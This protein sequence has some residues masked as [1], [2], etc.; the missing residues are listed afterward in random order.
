MSDIQRAPEVGGLSH[1]RYLAVVKALARKLIAE[2]EESCLLFLG[3]GAGFD[4]RR[5]HLP[6]AAEL[7]QELAKECKLE[8]HE[9]VPLSTVAFY[10]EFFYGREELNRF[11]KDR[12][13]DPGLQPS[14][15][16]ERL[17]E[18][19]AILEKLKRVVL[20]VTTNYDQHFERAYEAAFGKKPNVIVYNGGM[21]A[22]DPTA[23]LHSG[24]AKNLRTWQ[25]NRGTFLY[26]MH[27]C[28]TQATGR[29]LVVTEEDYV[30]FLSN[31]LSDFPTKRLPTYL[32]GRIEES[33]ILFVGYSLSDWNFRVI[34]KATAERASPNGVPTKESFA[35]QYIDMTEA[36]PIDQLRWASPVEFWGKKNVKIINADAALFV[37]DLVTALRELVP[38]GAL[39]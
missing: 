23:A 2:E 6:T 27:G 30:N 8:W 38:A 35:I 13:A 4:A 18:V 10:Y 36:K 29:N 5:K 33:S 19:I 12:I 21:D 31:A 11:L 9:Y 3:A 39:A 14:T 16:L 7:G 17:M 1:N 28:I 34:Y 24:L 37:E 32:L 22:N 25:P 15:T 20:V 26:K